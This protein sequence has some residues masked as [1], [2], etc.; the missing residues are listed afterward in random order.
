MSGVITSISSER[1]EGRLYIQATVMI[2]FYEMQFSRTKQVG[3]NSN[4]FRVVVEPVRFES[5][6]GQVTT[7]PEGI[8]GLSEY[9][10]AIFYP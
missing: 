4:T 8:G 5:L 6:V 9:L 2:L 3:S 1:G 7:P 10:Q